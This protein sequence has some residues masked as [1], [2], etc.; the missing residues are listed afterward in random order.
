M[1]YYWRGYKTVRSTL[2]EQYNL[3]SIEPNIQV[4]DVDA[5][6][7]RSLTLRHIQH[8]RRPLDISTYEVLKHVRRLWGFDVKIESVDENLNVVKAYECRSR[9]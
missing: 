2:S 7:D 8:L 1:L 3:G 4:Y 9:K 6:G 5:K